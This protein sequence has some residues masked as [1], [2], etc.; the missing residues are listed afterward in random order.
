RPPSRGDVELE[1]K[2]DRE[3]SPAEAQLAKNVERGISPREGPEALSRVLAGE[4]GPRVVVSS[5]D[6]TG[7]IRPAE[8]A[9]AGGPG[10]GIQ[11]ARPELES[12]YVEPTDE[13]EK[14]LVGFWKE[15]LGVDRV[16]IKDS[17]FDLGG[18]SLIAVRLFA[19][20]KRAFSV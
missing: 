7:L 19:K 10:G 11:L 12:A 1:G 15:L 9:A 3:R 20:V 14:T 4:H 6:L 18:H 16:G 13:I 8:R 2:G 5:L 17:F